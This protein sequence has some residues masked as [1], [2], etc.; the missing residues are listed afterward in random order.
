MLKYLERAISFVCVAAIVFT[1]CAVSGEE[2]PVEPDR[3]RADLGDNAEEGRAFGVFPAKFPVY[4]RS[5][6]RWTEQW[7]HWLSELPADRSPT[8]DLTADCAR[9]QD[10][11]VFFLPPFQ[12]PSFHRRCRARLG[13]PVLV[14]VQ[15]VLNSYPCPDPSF[16]PAPGQTLEEFLREGAVGY[17][18][19]YTDITATIDGNAVDLASHRHTTRLF[20]NTVHPSLLS[21]IP[22]PC[23]TGAPQPAVSDGWFFVTL[24]TPGQ[25]QIRIT[26]NN[27]GGQPVER[28]YD[29]EVVR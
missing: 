28:I 26:A 19:L 8:L 6:T 20:T 10:D 18:N 11:R 9:D 5:I 23:L 7:W 27:P 12:A 21:R 4:G 16:E 25:H 2:S 1:G 17:N 13:R 14:G 15:A 24:M 3:E 29:V 22:D